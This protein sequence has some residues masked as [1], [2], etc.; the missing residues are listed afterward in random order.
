MTGR[1]MDPTSLHEFRVLLEGQ[2]AEILTL[3]RRADAEARAACERPTDLG[4][5]SAET[6]AREFLFA[7]A[8]AKRRAL[9]MVE[10][11]LG[12]IRQGTFGECERCAEEIS[13]ARLRAIPWTRLC[14]GCQERLERG[15]GQVAA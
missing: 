1:V 11:A 10:E 8:E 7:Q 3:I 15:P 4:D 14:L 13:H 6:L 5:Q 9:R 2:R 12:R